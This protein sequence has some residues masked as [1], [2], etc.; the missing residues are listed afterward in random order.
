MEVLEDNEENVL[1]IFTQ[2]NIIEDVETELRTIKAG[3]C[4]DVQFVYEEGEEDDYK[5]E[6]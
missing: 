5:E 2:D 6:L 3:Y 1:S 4:K